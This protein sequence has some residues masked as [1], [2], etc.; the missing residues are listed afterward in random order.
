[1]ESALLFDEC[2]VQT[3]TGLL[4]VYQLSLMGLNVEVC[5]KQLCRYTFS[6]RGKKNVHAAVGLE[7]VPI[8]KY[9]C[10][11]L[12]VFLLVLE[13]EDLRRACSK[14]HHFS[15]ALLMDEKQKK[16]NNKPE[17]AFDFH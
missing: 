7:F 8:L 11:H 2:R 14:L 15:F 1:M 17:R 10:R 4:Y 6:S 3:N 13:L 12:D 5:Y 9:I 16:Y